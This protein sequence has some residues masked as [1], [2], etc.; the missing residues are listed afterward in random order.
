MDDLGF[1]AVKA[2]HTDPD[3]VGLRINAPELGTVGF[4]GDTVYYPGLSEHYKGVRLLMLCVMWPRGDPI[5]RHLNTDDALRVIE[6]TRP[7]CA[8]LTHMGMR[9]LNAD[10]EKEAEHLRN[11][12]GVPV[13]VASDGMT[14]TVGDRI[15]FKGPRKS[16]EEFIIDA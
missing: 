5:S 11:E 9:M 15:I 13:V 6:E 1:E 12:T 14:A 4:T 7:G 8:V 3:T 10:P 16:D 2:V